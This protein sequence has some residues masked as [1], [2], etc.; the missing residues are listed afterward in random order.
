MKQTLIR[1]FAVAAGALWIS[2]ASGA[3]ATLNFDTGPSNTVA[4]S[5]GAPYAFNNY[6]GY[7]SAVLNTVRPV[8]GASA[9]SGV[10]N[11]GGQAL[12]FTTPGTASPKTVAG[13]KFTLVCKRRLKSAAGSCV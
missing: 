1:L 9:V 6:S 13:S 8:S 11:G 10:G 7:R 4:Y 3:I 5:G 12:S 2:S